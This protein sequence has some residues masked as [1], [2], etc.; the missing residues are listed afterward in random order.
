MAL[1]EEMC[2]AILLYMKE[3]GISQSTLSQKI[4]ISAPKLNM[5]LQCKRRLTLEEYAMICSA[6]NVNADMFLK[7]RA[8]DK[9][10]N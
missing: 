2:Q 3:Q 8:P 10:K 7:P 1:Q 4:G 6:L 5:A 9:T